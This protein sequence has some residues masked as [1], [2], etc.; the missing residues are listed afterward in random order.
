MGANCIMKR[1]FGNNGVEAFD[2]SIHEVS[3]GGD[4]EPLFLL[5]STTIPGP[6]LSRYYLLF[7]NDQILEKNGMVNYDYCLDLLETIG[8]FVL[9]EQELQPFFYPKE[10][11]DKSN[12]AKQDLI[13]EL[14]EFKKEIKV[15]QYRIIDSATN[16]QKLYFNNLISLTRILGRKY[17]LRK[18]RISRQQF[19]KFIYTLQAGHIYTEHYRQISSFCLIY[20]FR[21]KKP[22]VVFALSK[23]NIVL[24]ITE[25]SESVLL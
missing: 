25:G 2:L 8:D 7:E 6:L 19:E 18:K 3:F 13:E 5:K 21:S 22:V 4:N 14:T 20:S 17:Y 10:F 16:V 9:E 11:L 23:K 12:M 24:T 15:K 1:S